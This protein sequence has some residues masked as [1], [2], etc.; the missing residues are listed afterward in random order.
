MEKTQN[1]R[2]AVDAIVFGYSKDIGVS[3]LLIKRKYKP[4]IDEWAIPGGFVDVNESLEEA[5]QREL[6]EETGVNINYLEQLYTF[7]KLKRDPRQSA[8][9]ED[10]YLEENK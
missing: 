7:G 2:L 10:F 6:S 9:L 4:Y 5:V 3:V 1:I 8:Q